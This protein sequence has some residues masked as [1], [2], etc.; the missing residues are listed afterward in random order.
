MA[1]VLASLWPWL[2]LRR[3]HEV[4]FWRVHCALL[5]VPFTAAL[6]N[7][8]FRRQTCMLKDFGERY[9]D[10]AT[11][12][13]WLTHDP[14]LPLAALACVAAYALG[15]RFDFVK[16]V[17]LPVNLAFVPMSIWVWDLPFTD[18]IVCRL[19][20][21]GRALLAPGVPLRSRHLHALGLVATALFVLLE[22]RHARARGE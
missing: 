7:I 15:Q 14:S 13:R 19:A 22:R 6:H 8:V 2:G 10:P 1:N 17:L 12:Q 21:D 16:L 11:L 5:V 9:T 4:A 3:R 20:H 18:R